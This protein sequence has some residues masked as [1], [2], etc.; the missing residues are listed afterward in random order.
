MLSSLSC[1][2]NFS[3]SIAVWTLHFRYPCGLRSHTPRQDSLLR[4]L[5]TTTLHFLT[6]RRGSRSFP[7][8]FPTVRHLLSCKEHL[9]LRH[10]SARLCPSVSHCPFFHTTPLWTI[11]ALLPFF[12]IALQLGL[13]LVKISGGTTRRSYWVLRGVGALV[14]IAVSSTHQPW[15]RTSKGRLT[16]TSSSPS[17]AC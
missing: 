14:L 4:S 9:L 3:R 10:H 5:F 17:S 2:C 6:G 8:Q 13:W 16:W 12:R 7:V 15:S 11:V 1:L